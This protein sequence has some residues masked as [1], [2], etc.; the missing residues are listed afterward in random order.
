MK[1][2]LV[3]FN[4]VVGDIYNNIK[5]ILK[6]LDE[7]ISKK[8]DMAVFP[9]LAVCG[10]PPKDLLDK[11]SFIN[12]NRQAV[13]YLIPVS[14]KIKIIV[15]FVDI[16]KT[17]K[18]KNLYNSAVYLDGGEIKSVSHK[19]LLPTYD[20]F[21]E[22][23]YFL[24]SEKV[25][26]LKIDNK[27]FGLSICEDLWFE[28][29]PKYKF[30]PIKKLSETG[31]DY[32]INISSSPYEE[33]KFEKRL[34][35]VT[36]VA[37]KIGVPVLYVNQVGANDGV[38][39]DGGAIVADPKGNL[40]AC[41][42]RFKEQ[43]LIFDTELP[44]VPIERNLI[45]A[46]DEII[47]ALALGLRDYTH[48]TGFKKVVLGLSGGIDSALTAVIA[49]KAL[50]NNNVIGV[51]MPSRF[52]SDGSKSDAEKL[53]GNL[54]IDFLTIPI[55]PLFAQYIDTLSAA[56][57][58]KPWD[59]A[60]ENIQ[61][62]IRGNILMALANKHGWMVLS[63]G[64]KSELAVGYCTLYGD[65]C[66]GVA[67][68]SDVFKTK[69][70]KLAQAINRNREI[71]PVE[72]IIKVPSAELRHNQTDQD[73]LPE[74]ALLDSILKSYIEEYKGVEE[75]VGMGYD[76]ET[77]LKVVQMVD[78]SEYKRK[79]ACLGLKVSVKAFGEGRRIPIVQNYVPLDH[80]NPLTER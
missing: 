69:V 17:I 65:M 13:E 68:I 22:D 26:V 43:Y 61:A 47:E 64:N 20:V 78:R 37:G 36:S 9:E 38:I 42:E 55:E 53:A 56:F 62:R 54:K 28:L 72:S 5:S 21:D 67:V 19:C 29:T 79:Q 46:D 70:Y 10:Y 16:D 24:P 33:E 12:D 34:D 66:G 50:G 3:S 75:I 71:I 77:V 30:D 1:I 73:S 8:V 35:L 44:Y 63:T 7:L 80:C 60:E 31:I 39:F 40:I 6:I 23:R 27:T 52:S 32:L 48:K 76:K 41:G 14:E 74:Y 18:G 59:I 45:D 57:K 25:T 49:V 51:S 4:P 11:P 58:N 2:A 15:G